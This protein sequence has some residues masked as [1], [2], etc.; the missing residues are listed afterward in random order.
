MYYETVSFQRPQFLKQTKKYYPDVFNL[1]TRLQF[2]MFHHT[3]KMSKNLL[4]TGP[5][6][7]L[8]IDFSY[9]WPLNKKNKKDKRVYRVYLSF[10]EC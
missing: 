7:W 6:N 8:K 4:K 9:P 10:V 5:F 1:G 3:D 2:T